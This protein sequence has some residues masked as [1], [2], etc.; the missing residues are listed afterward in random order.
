MAATGGEYTQGFVAMWFDPKFEPV[1][2]NGFEPEIRSVGYRPF[3]IDKKHYVGGITD[4]PKFAARDFRV[5]DYTEQVNGVYFEAGFALGLG[6]TVIPTAPM[7][8]VNCILTF[9]T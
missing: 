2:S 5:A 6:L 1:W 8:S 7:K 4:D 3:G 9:G